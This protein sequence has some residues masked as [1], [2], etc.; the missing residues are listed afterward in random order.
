RAASGAVLRFA[1][2]RETAV[3]APE[4]GA[5]V[6][7]V[8]RGDLV[9]VGGE[10]TL[11]R[12]LRRAAARTMTVRESE[13]LL[14]SAELAVPEHLVNGLGRRRDVDASGLRH[15]FFRQ[16]DDYGAE[17]GDLDAELREA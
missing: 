16:G 11:L 5:V 6:L 2:V 1:P 8:L 10:I 15:V 3:R 14:R 4:V 9:C 17:G 12:V 7:V 13:Q